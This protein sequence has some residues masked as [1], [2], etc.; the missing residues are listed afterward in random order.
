MLN[1]VLS[2]FRRPTR[3]PSE[4]VV[5]MLAAFATGHSL[6]R[7]F[8]ERLPEDAKAALGTLNEIEAH[9]IDLWLVNEALTQAAHNLPDDKVQS[10]V[11][12]FHW[13]TYRQFLAHGLS[14]DGLKE[15]QRLLRERYNQYGNALAPVLQGAGTKASFTFSRLVT[16]NLFGHE[17]GDPVVA[18]TIGGSVAA[19]LFSTVDA[20]KDVLPRTTFS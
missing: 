8:L 6:S 12:G 1:R 17:S 16:R 4:A 20:L 7:Q 5:L 11:D 18:L 2:L 19:A 14:A 10:L 15:L 9:L 3:L 13:E